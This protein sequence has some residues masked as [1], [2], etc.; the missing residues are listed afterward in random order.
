VDIVDKILKVLLGIVIWVAIVSGGLFT[1]AILCA[2]L[3]AVGV[4]IR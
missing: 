1:V 4:G 3:S 2:V